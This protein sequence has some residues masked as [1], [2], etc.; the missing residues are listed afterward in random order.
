MQR[1]RKHVS[2]HAES[3]GGKSEHVLWEEIKSLSRAAARNVMQTMV[4]DAAEKLL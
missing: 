2:D 1:R 3:L 4:R